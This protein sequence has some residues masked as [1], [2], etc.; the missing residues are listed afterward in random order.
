MAKLKKEA[1]SQNLDN[2]EILWGDI[3]NVGGVKLTDNSIDVAIVSNVLFQATAKY[4]LALEVKRILKSTGRVLFVDWS[5]SFSGLGP[6]SS[7]IVTAE[8]A[9]KIFTEAGFSVGK[10][11]SAGPHH[12]GSIF[13]KK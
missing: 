10:S 12:Y 6:Q 1:I 7:D 9:Q 5:E 8:E 13:I 4:Q 2:I 11:F 3:E